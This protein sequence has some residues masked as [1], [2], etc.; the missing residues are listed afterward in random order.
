MTVRDRLRRKE[1]MTV[2]NCLSFLRLLLI[3]VFVVLYMKYEEYGAATLVI[4]ISAATD[5]VDGAIARRF[6]MISDFGKFLDPVADKLT[7]A[8][9]I[10]C[11]L[12]DYSIMWGLIVLFAVKEILMFTFGFLILK[13]SDVMSSAKWYGK[14]NTFV[15]D[16]VMCVLFFF[17]DIPG[18]VGNAMIVTCGVFMV[19]SVALYMRFY[20]GELKRIRAAGK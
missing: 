1:I 20:I 7:Q 5:V 17:H 4:L 19:G 14:V 3:P 13:R 12:S 9:T 16:T 6:D 18:Y 2:P 8:A 15:T 11:L 10:I